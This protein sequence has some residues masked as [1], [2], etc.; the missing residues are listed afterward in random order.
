VTAAVEHGL[1][2]T[3]PKDQ[4]LRSCANQICFLT[5]RLSDSSETRASSSGT[6][7]VR[8]A[9][10]KQGA[11]VRAVVAICKVSV[12][13]SLEIFDRIR[14]A[15]VFAFWICYT[16]YSTACTCTKIL[17]EYGGIA[18]SDFGSPIIP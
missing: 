17:R 13:F 5:M 9:S 18:V 6:Y 10:K 2:S 7:S 12:V 3:G 8:R 15:S 16:K 1:R 11:G 4:R 14:S